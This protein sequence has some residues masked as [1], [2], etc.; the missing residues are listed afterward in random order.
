VKVRLPGTATEVAE[1]TGRLLEV[2]DVVAVSDP[3]PDRGTSVL[4][5]VYLEV[6]LDHLAS[7][8]DDRG[9]GG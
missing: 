2:G 7:D 5:R 6:R 9:V 3:F 8:R 4:V 1:A